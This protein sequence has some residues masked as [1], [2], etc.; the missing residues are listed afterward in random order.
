MSLLNVVGLAGA[1]NELLIEGVQISSVANI[2]ETKVSKVALTSQ[3]M[4]KTRFCCQL[5]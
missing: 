4:E 1:I 3:S 2:R 5:L